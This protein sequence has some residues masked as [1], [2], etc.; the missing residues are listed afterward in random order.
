M[1][2]ELKEPMPPTHP[3]AA[4]KDLTCGRCQWLNSGFNGQNCFLS[5]QVELTTPA[6]IEFTERLKDPFHEILRDKYIL[7]IR[8]ALKTRKYNLNESLV[9]ELRGYIV[10]DNLS[11]L[12]YGDSKDIVR[13]SRILGEIISH[14]G[15]VTT[16]YTQ[17]LETKYDMEEMSD[18][19]SL[20][21]YSKYA[22]IRELKNEVQRKAA[23]NRLLP[24]LM[25]IRKNLH[26][27]LDLAAHLDNRLDA[28]ER[29]IRTIL[30]STEKL[31][32]SKEGAY[33]RHQ[34]P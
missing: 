31:W 25:P 7:G 27:V 17:A 28:T 5:R 19:I 4:T 33:A 34:R 20:W 12:N 29:T 13:L 26:K 24:E 18:Q 6:C 15:R 2:A 14:R 23:E 10:E 3:E 8:E 1:T 21:L 30:D 22:V 9:D 11:D 16:I 32:Y